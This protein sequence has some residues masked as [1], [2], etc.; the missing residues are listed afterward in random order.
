MGE[1]N[2]WVEKRNGAW[3]KEMQGLRSVMEREPMIYTGREECW[4]LSHGTTRLEKRNGAWRHG[5]SRVEKRNG[6]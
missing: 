1:G 5:I 3:A 4:S 6:A 2:A